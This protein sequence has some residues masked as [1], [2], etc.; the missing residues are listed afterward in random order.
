MIDPLELRVEG[1]KD[2]V[3]PVHVNMMLAEMKDFVRKSHLEHQ[4]HIFVVVLTEPRG[5]DFQEARAP[6]SRTWTEQTIFIGVNT[7]AQM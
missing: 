2:R 6:Q 5:E 7:A 3:R 1:G 4:V